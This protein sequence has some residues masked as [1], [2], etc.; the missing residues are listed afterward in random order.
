MINRILSS[1]NLY[2]DHNSEQRGA[3]ILEI[4]LVMGIIAVLSPFI[5]N[6]ISETSE[7]IRDISIA[8]QIINLRDP[9]LNFVRLNQDKWP[10]TAQIKLSDNEL[11]QITGSARAGFIDKYQIHGSTVTDIY[12]AF[13]LQGNAIHTAKVAKQIGIDAATVANDGVAYGISWAVTAPGFQPGDLVYRINYNFN[14]DDISK[15]LHRTTSGKDEFNVMQ[16]KLHMNRFNIYNI[17]TVAAESAK[18]KDT[19]AAFVEL[20][21]SAAGS[22]YFSNGANMDAE[23]VKIGSMRVSDDISGFRN[24]SA[25]KLNN[26]GFSTTGNIIADKATVNNSLNV[27]NNLTIKSDSTKTV[28]GFSGIIAHSIY[29]SFLYSDEIQFYNNFGLTVSGE[30]L[31]SSTPPIKIGNWSFPSSTPPNF[32]E[33]GLSRATVPNMPNNN[34]FDKILKTGWKN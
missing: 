20:K 6:Q 1:K 32:S 25:K 16:R 31:M 21:D 33:L 19:S 34:D 29:T 26:D 14:G 13:G 28:S 5:Y 15:Y 7:Q 10:D 11:D 8:K 27:G 4:L 24:I 3:S 22:V 18:F 9:A 2:T 23:N 12:L 17:G 30:L